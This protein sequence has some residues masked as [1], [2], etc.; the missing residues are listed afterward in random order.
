MN[1]RNINNRVL[2]HYDNFDTLDDY[3]MK[4]NGNYMLSHYDGEDRIM[5]KKHRSY[6]LQQQDYDNLHEDYSINTTTT[7][8]SLSPSPSEKLLPCRSF[9]STGTCCYGNKCNF[10]HDLR[11]TSTYFKAEKTSRSNLKKF[12]ARERLEVQD[13][14]FW[15]PL[16]HQ[17][18]LYSVPLPASESKRERG[19]RMRNE[20]TVVR[21]F[22]NI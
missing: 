16:N 4:N 9:I 17:S 12:K 10:I 22:I 19:L 7:M 13:S 21:I 14:F 18:E 8:E 11:M 1:Y 2:P 20:S 5:D 15:P 3:G 6:L